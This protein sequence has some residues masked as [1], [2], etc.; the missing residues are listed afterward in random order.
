MGEKTNAMLVFALFNTESGNVIIILNRTMAD[1]AIAV[2]F[3]LR[4]L[5][6][7]VLVP[8]HS[9]A[10]RSARKPSP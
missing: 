4:H 2:S 6:L 5:D 8:F 9:R 10:F 7:G 3:E 1:I